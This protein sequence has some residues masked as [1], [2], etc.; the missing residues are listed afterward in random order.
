ATLDL[1]ARTMS[2][3]AGASAAAEEVGKMQ[4][5]AEALQ[6]ALGEMLQAHAV[7]DARA[8]LDDGDK[9]GPE[10]L[11]KLKDLL[12]LPWLEGADRAKLWAG[13][14]KLTARLTAKALEQ[15]AQDNQARKQTPAPP[16]ADASGVAQR[17]RDRA[18]LRASASRDLL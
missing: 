4:R 2:P 7:P 3:P 14:R 13:L 12:R 1:Q 18:L 8:R 9:A 10:D 15:D 17:E 6:G 5:S 16:A 11:R